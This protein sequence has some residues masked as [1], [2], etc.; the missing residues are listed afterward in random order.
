MPTQNNL[1]THTLLLAW[2]HQLLITHPKKNISFTAYP[3]PYQQHIQQNH[4]KSNEICAC[5]K[6]IRLFITSDSVALDKNENVYKIPRPLWPGIAN[7][8]PNL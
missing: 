3:H 4:H 7:M 5:M 6:K 2:F 8:L 1:Q